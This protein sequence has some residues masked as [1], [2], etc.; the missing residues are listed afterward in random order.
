[1]HVYFIQ[2][3][4]CSWH[5]KCLLS[6]QKFYLEN[7]VFF[8]F[9]SF[10]FYVKDRM[11]KEVLLSN[12]SR[13]GLYVLSESSPTSLPQVFSSTCLSTSADV[14]H[15]RLEHPSP[16]ILY[17]L[18]KNKKVSYTSNQFNFNCPA[19][20][21]GKSCHLTLETTGHQTR[22]PLNLI[23]SD[24]WV[25]PLCCHLMVFSILL[26]LSMLI[27]SLFGFILWLLSLMFLIFFI[28]FRH[29]LSANFF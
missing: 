10:L 8:E 15:R 9:H 28:N 19:C 6:V 4:T 11:T 20:P 17:F 22:A 26:S 21:L 24:V 5:K 13:D 3:F 2:Y 14:W 7:T 1:M 29:S 27:Q 23:F 18:V 12:W 16:H 25:P